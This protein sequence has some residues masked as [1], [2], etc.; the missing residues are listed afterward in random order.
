[1]KNLTS[2]QKTIRLDINQVEIPSNAGIGQEGTTEGILY[3]YIDDVKEHLTTMFDG[4]LKMHYDL[5]QFGA[6]IK[7]SKKS[8]NSAVKEV[9]KKYN[10]SKKKADKV[11]DQQSIDDEKSQIVL[12]REA[13]DF[14]VYH[15]YLTMASKK[16]LKK[17]VIGVYDSI[18]KALVMRPILEVNE[19]QQ[20]SQS[21]KKK[22]AKKYES[23]KNLPATLKHTYKCIMDSDS[24][25]TKEDALSGLQTS[26]AP[27][28]E[29]FENGKMAIGNKIDG[30]FEH[31]ERL[32][33]PAFADPSSQKIKA[34]K[35][36]SSDSSPEKNIGSSP[37]KDEE[38]PYELEDDKEVIRM[39][40]LDA[41]DNIQANSINTKLEPDI[42]KS[43][44]MES[45]TFLKERLS[46]IINKDDEAMMQIQNFMT[47]N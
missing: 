27:R 12:E 15:F 36:S 33:T 34:V 39:L 6:K 16:I 7:E 22:K 45:K 9:A 13:A 40:E 46:C 20:M 25:E 3:N 5:K 47:E 17:D 37:D 30:L 32:D 21:N 29:V 11:R 8:N 42:K 18:E 10:E 44:R 28:R 26:Y 4:L 35:K 23:Q 38:D 1:V 41:K 31:K 2:I 14:Q 43:I 24:E 19:P